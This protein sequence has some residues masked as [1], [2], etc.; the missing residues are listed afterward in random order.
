[1]S[2]NL[3]LLLLVLLGLSGYGQDITATVKAPNT[4][5]PGKDLTVE[6]SVNKPG[7]SGF[8][9]YFQD[10]PASYTATDIDSKGGNFTNADN[11]AKIIWISP[12]SAD[13][14]TMTYKIAI[15]Q[16]ASGSISVGGKFSYVVGN[17]RKTFD[18]APQVVTIG[19]GTASGTPAPPVKEVVKES[20][21]PAET[22][23]PVTETKPPVAESKP[24][25]PPAEEKPKPVEPKKETPVVITPPVNK[26]P[27]SAAPT[28]TAGRSYRVQIGAFAL[29]PHIEGVPESSTVVLDNGMT[30]YFSGNFKTYEEAKKRKNEMIDKGFQGAFIVAFENGK[31]V[32]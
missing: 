15:P 7:V 13:Q 29:K 1:M 10:L 20:P 11:G 32:K 12:P 27:T 31:I 2:K 17:E 19:N 25:P 23:P 21:P 24:T 6:V 3:S 30:K 16:G 8:M 4:V 26:A 5:A 18:V 9:K 14:F 22:K 28:A